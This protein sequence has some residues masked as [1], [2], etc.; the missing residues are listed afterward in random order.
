MMAASSLCKEVIA[1]FAIYTEWLICIIDIH[2]IYRIHEKCNV[3]IEFIGLN[4]NILA[5]LLEERSFGSV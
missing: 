5:F 2:S 3:T 4:T 1:S